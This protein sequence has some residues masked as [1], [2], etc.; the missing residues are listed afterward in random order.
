[1]VWNRRSKMRQNIK[2]T[3]HASLPCMLRPRAID[4][5]CGIG[6]GDEGGGDGEGTKCYGS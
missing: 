1:M 2:L 3:V 5:H 6:G 4:F